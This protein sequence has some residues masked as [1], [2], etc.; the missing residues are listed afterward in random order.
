V[1][2]IYTMNAADGSAQTNVVNDLA[3]NDT[4][5]DWMAAGFIASAADFTF[6]PATSKPKLGGSVLWN[7]VGPSDHTVTDSS[8]TANGGVAF[9]DSG[10]V[11]AGGYYVFTFQAA[12]QYPYICSIHAGMS[13]TVKVPMTVAPT[14]GST[15]T[16]FTVTWASGGPP[17][18]YRFDVQIQKPG[19]PGFLDWLPGTALKTSTF[20]PNAGVGTYLW[21]A[22]LHRLSDG[23]TSSW[24]APVSVVVS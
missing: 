6:T 13:G 24:S 4:T 15:T 22:R 16:V 12:G 20:T 1:Y 9:F 17:V 5:P 23:D 2:E 10:I 8:F 11:S 3:F 18:G 19:D 21:Q 7:F 14:T